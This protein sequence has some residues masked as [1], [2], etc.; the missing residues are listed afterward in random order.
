MF[1]KIHWEI[2][3]GLTFV[4]S[5]T[6]LAYTLLSS[7]PSFWT[8]QNIWSAVLILCWMIVA[9]GYWH[10]GWIIRKAGSATHVSSVLPMAVFVVQCILFV[11]GV[12]YEDY[13]L[14]TGAVMVN[15]AV[16]FN[17]YQIFRA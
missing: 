8:A 10:Q 9:G 14:V 6:F 2:F 15:S 4:A 7:I 11:K 16:V 3:L 12:H 5:G 17:L 13:S 1:K